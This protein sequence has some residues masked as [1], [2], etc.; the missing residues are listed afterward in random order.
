MLPL[1]ITEILQETEERESIVYDSA[2]EWRN[3]E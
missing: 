1:L 3:G 2:G